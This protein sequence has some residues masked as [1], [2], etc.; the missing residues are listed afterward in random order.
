MEEAYLLLGSNLGDSRKYLSDAIKA[1]SEQA[2]QLIATSSIYQTAAW[3]NVEQPDFLNQVVKLETILT[4]Q[5]L[6]KNILVIEENLGRRRIEKWG[7]RTIDIDLLFYGKQIIRD[8]NLIVPH[9]FLHLR[10]FTLM[11]LVELEP[12]LL[13]PVLNKTVTELYNQLDDQLSVTKL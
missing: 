9:P 11:P 5:Q 1:I 12:E 6:L 8:E 2:G 13:H 4:A 3:G 7:S 10:R